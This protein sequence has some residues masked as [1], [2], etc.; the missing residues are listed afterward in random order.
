MKNL[1]KSFG[2]VAVAISLNGS[3]N[4]PPKIDLHVHLTTRSGNTPMVRYEK[5]AALS[6]QMGVAFGIAEEIASNDVNRNER[7]ILELASLIKKYPMYLGLQ[8]NQPGWS[9]LYSKKSLDNVDFIMEDALRF[10]DKDGRIRLLWYP[11]VVFNDP[12]DF[13]ER[14]VEYNLLV[15]SESITIWVNPTFLPES[16]KKRYDELWTEKRMKKLIDAAV[17]N[18]IAIEINSRYQI[19]GKKFIQMA[20]AAGARFTF[21]SNQHDTNIGEIEWSVKMAR[22]C[23]LEKKDFFIPK[24]ILE[25][26]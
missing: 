25:I 4:D 10:P 14:Y 6:K 21:G 19:P 18:N 12:Q 11:D 15:L 7:E 20:K 26:R 17:K 22:E 9:I 13:M 8:V 23:G 2:L 24:R 3:Q 1:L 5:A 16:L